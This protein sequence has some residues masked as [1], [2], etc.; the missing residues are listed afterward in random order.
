MNTISSRT[1]IKDHKRR[2]CCWQK[3]AMMLVLL[4]ANMANAADRPLEIEQSNMQ[5]PIQVGRP[6][7]SWWDVKVRGTGLLEG[8]FEFQLKND[9]QLLS[10][11]VTDEIY[12]AFLGDPWEGRSFQHGHTYTGNPLACAAALASIQLFD[13]RNVLDNVQ[14]LEVAMR[15]E[16]APLSSSDSG[17][18]QNSIADV[19]QRGVMV[20][21][22]LV[23]D[24]ISKEPFH[25]S[26]RI[27]HQVTLA[28]RRRGVILRNIGDTVVL[29]P[30]P[31]MP[32]SLL[33]QICQ[34][35]VQS[36]EE[37]LADPPTLHG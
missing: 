8:H 32:E 28:C 16:L 23:R 5:P 34:A 26:L 30:A 12:D 3:Y 1:F 36:L 31:A 25:G 24:R 21:I 9:G 6:I 37:V 27:G 29:M 19:R 14:R 11:L 35:V 22:E 18:F 33:R 10:T 4:L 2:C 20:G 17:A 13:E 7:P 15:E